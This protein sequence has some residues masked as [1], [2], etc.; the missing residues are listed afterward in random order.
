MAASIGLT[1]AQEAP[2]FLGKPGFLGMVQTS[3]YHGVDIP[4]AELKLQAKTIAGKTVAKID[5]DG[6]EVG[7]SLEEV[8][9]FSQP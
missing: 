6:S 7:Q 5:F 1:A 9:I 8:T 2:L 3:V 4:D